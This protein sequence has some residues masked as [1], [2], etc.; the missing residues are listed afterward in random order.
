M[1]TM[2]LDY[3]SKKGFYDNGNCLS[4]SG[5]YV[6]LTSIIDLTGEF[7]ISF[8]LNKDD[9][10]SSARGGVLGS[11]TNRGISTPSESVLSIGDNTGTTILNFIHLVPMELEVWNHV[12]IT[13]NSSNEIRVY[14]NAQAPSEQ[15]DNMTISIDE[16]FRTGSKY[17]FGKIDDICIWDGV[18]AS[19]QDVVDI[20]NNGNGIDPISVISN[21][22]LHLKLN[23]SGSDSIAND[24]SINGNN[25]TLIAFPTSGM[26]LNHDSLI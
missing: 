15:I 8:W 3:V 16:I 21:P 19:I 23:E 4:G 9:V 1:S 2:Y 7:I 5:A 10:T 20:Y 26:W 6:S 13:R 14:L 18:S 25:G 12:L 24:S 22:E 17:L 11:G